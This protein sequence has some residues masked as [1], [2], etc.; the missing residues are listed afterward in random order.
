ML[1]M[2]ITV[3]RCPGCREFAGVLVGEEPVM[4]LKCD[5]D[6]TQEVR[7]AAERDALEALPRGFRLS[8]ESLGRWLAGQFMRSEPTR[9][10]SWMELLVG[11]VRSHHRIALQESFYFDIFARDYA[12]RLKVKD[13]SRRGRMF[14][15]FVDRVSAT[16]E[17]APRRALGWDAAFDREEY[18]IRRRAYRSSVEHGDR[19][20]PTAVTCVFLI[21][22]AARRVRFSDVV[23]P[24]MKDLFSEGVSEVTHVLEN[25]RIE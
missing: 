13:P 11:R 9:P 14:R 16:V 6:I 10:T 2:Q 12:I 24:A 15:A 4:C 21:L 8:P 1:P 22:L 5:R 23:V 25:C 7:E 20:P 19:Q 17:L 18:L 3:V